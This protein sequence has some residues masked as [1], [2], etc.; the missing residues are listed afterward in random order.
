MQVQVISDRVIYHHQCQKP[1]VSKQNILYIRT[2]IAIICLDFLCCSNGRHI[3]WWHGAA[4]LYSYSADSLV[5]FSI[6]LKD[7]SARQIH[8]D[9]LVWAIVLYLNGS[10]PFSRG[11]LTYCCACMH[12]LILPTEF[13]FCQALRRAEVFPSMQMVEIRD[14]QSAHRGIKSLTLIP[15]GSLE[16]PVFMTYSTVLSFDCGR[17]V[18]LPIKPT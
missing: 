8:A 9:S 6:L 16:T 4:A 1:F 13:I 5:R 14:T 11:H 10:A 18:E 3:S 17:K 15:V 7:T 2:T 12:S